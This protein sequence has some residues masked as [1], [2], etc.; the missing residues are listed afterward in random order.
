MCFSGQFGYVCIRWAFF[1]WIV[2]DFCVSSEVF[3]SYF[4][5]VIVD[6]IGVVFSSY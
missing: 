1:Y 2:Y 4:Q 3:A 6:V 5:R